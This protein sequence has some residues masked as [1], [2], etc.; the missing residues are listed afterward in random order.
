MWSPVDLHSVEEVNHSQALKLEASSAHI[1][2]LEIIQTKE[3][4]FFFFNIRPQI[5]MVELRGGGEEREK[6]SK[7]NE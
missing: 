5:Y 4:V 3:T 2:R 1:H 6:C 7:Y